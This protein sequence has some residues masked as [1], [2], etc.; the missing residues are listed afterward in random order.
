MRAE[1]TLCARHPAVRKEGKTAPSRRREM[2][3]KRRADRLT[4]RGYNPG[5]SP[6]KERH[7]TRQYFPTNIF[8]FRFAGSCGK[9]GHNSRRQPDAPPRRSNDTRRSSP[10]S[11]QSSKLSSRRNTQGTWAGFDGDAAA[12]TGLT[13]W[14]GPCKRGSRAISPSFW[15]AVCKG[16][17]RICVMP[18]YSQ[19]R[20]KIRQTIMVSRPTVHKLPTT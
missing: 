19:L 4:L 3:V 5:K 20:S 10:P 16:S 12:G 11:G 14:G 7:L 13:A 1:A 6:A 15:N 8:L 18:A 17:L 2:D 9:D